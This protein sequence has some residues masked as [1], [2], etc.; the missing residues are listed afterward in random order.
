[1][2]VFMVVSRVVLLCLELLARRDC[3][4]LRLKVKLP[5]GDLERSLLI[6]FALYYIDIDRT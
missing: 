5:G 6:L 2:R 1:M 3:N 4:L